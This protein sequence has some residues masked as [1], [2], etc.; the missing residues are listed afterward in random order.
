M[1]QIELKKVLH[2]D[3]VT[4][5]FTRVGLPSPR[6][7]IGA[8]VG[9]S[10]NGYLDTQILGN[11]YYL[12][13]LAW[14]YINGV[15]PKFID[16]ID[17]DRSNN[18]ISNLRSIDKK[19]NHKNMKKPKSNTSGCSGVYMHPV[20]KRWIANICLNGKTKYL[21]SFDD[22]NLAV[23]AR[24]KAEKDNGFHTNHGR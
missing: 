11:R 7:Q 2:Y 3:E 23:K 20:N 18:S 19:V 6:S 12:H 1:T 22:F 14:L 16:H 13:R 9:S 15:E 24:K 5:I 17:G 10:N 4:G 8:V 21:G